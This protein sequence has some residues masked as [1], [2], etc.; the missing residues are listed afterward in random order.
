MANEQE[1]EISKGGGLTMTETTK[2]DGSACNQTRLREKLK[3]DTLA[4]RL[5]DAYDATHT[6]EVN[7]DA[8]RKAVEAELDKVRKGIEEN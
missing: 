7:Q 1:L 6:A 5:A 8:L 2:D 3:A 4:R